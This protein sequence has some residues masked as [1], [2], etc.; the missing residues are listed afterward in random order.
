MTY[1][2]DAFND[3]VLSVPFY[4]LS[5]NT[6]YYVPKSGSIGSYRDFISMLPNI[7]KPDAFGQNPNADIASQIRET[8]YIEHYSSVP[9][10]LLMISIFEKLFPG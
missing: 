8:R 4:Q 3:N 5:A 1:V 9:E 2:N 10:K 6:H 7:D